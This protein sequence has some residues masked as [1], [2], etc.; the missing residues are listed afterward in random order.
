V[1]RELLIAAIPSAIMLGCIA[2][3]DRL[4]LNSDVSL[5]VGWIGGAVGSMLWYE[6]RREG[7]R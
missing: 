4:G 3:V 5:L 1:K 6:L 2:F 7:V